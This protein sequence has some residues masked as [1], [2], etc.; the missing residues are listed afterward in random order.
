MH[1]YIYNISDEPAYMPKKNITQIHAC[2]HSH[3]LAS[4]LVSISK[5]CCTNFAGAVSEARPS[6]RGRSPAAQGKSCMHAYANGY[7]HKT[8]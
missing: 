2:M 6:A 8:L 5:N 7:N 1:M 4:P 3:P